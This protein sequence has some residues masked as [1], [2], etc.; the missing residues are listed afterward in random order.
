MRLVG[1]GLAGQSQRRQSRSVLV[2]RGILTGS[3]LLLPAQG[4]G[5]GAGSSGGGLGGQPAAEDDEGQGRPEGGILAEGRRRIWMRSP[6]LLVSVGDDDGSRRRS[7]RGGRGALVL[8]LL[9]LGGGGSATIGDPVASRG[10]RAAGTAAAVASCC[11][12]H[13]GRKNAGMQN[14]KWPN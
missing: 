12:G 4:A 1:D 7:G 5:G 14:A 13:G 8:V 2:S 10:P 6:R 9:L 3:L 11:D